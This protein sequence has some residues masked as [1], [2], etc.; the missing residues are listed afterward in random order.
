MYQTPY[1]EGSLEKQSFLVTGGAGFIGSHLV[2]YLLKF[3]AGK[4][5]VLDNF[6]TGRKSNI[7]KFFSNP[8]FEL[9]EG[10][11]RDLNICKK[12]CK[13]MKF[14]AHQAALGSVP[15]SVIDPITTNAINADGF[16][17]ILEAAK[18]EKVQRIVYASSSS[19]YG[20]EK[21][22]PKKETKTGNPLSP[23]AVTKVTNELYAN[24]FSDIYKMEIAGLRYFNVFGP[25]Q[26]PSGPYAA[27][28]PIF[29]QNTLE[30]K[31]VNV[32]GDG[33]QTRDFTFVENA[34]QANVRALLNTNV[35]EKHEVFNIGCGDNY[36]INDLCNF[37]SDELAIN[38]IIEHQPSRKGDIKD[39]LANISKAETMI[40]YHPKFDLKSGLKHTVNFYKEQA[41]EK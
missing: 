31:T 34:V 28:V 19:V 12:A 2:E 22:L 6:I 25:R 40:G 13:G 20:D 30:G 11:T 26:D 38:M 29:I 37:I 1:H 9:I 23:Y 39:S 3:N 16:L 5:R 21:T 33:M 36:T 32:H 7:D 24:V 17:N 4:V 14:V 8:N 15:R 41:I 10:D 35:M 18:Q 27:V